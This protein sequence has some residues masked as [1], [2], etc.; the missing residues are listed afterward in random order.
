MQAA[1]WKYA[2]KGRVQTVE[3]GS[4]PSQVIDYAPVLWFPIRHRAKGEKL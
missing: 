2:P 3:Q 1:L 4:H